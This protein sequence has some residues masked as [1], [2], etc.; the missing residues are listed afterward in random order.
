MIFA[1]AIILP[2]EKPALIR[3]HDLKDLPSWDEM[4]R[5][6]KAL[7]EGTFPFPMR[8]SLPSGTWQTLFSVSLTGNDTLSS[9]YTELIG[10]PNS[11]FSAITGTITQIRCNIYAGASNYTIDKIYIDNAAASGDVWDFDGSPV[12]L[13]VG[14]SNTFTVTAGTEQ[15]TDARAFTRVAGRGIAIRI[16]RN[17]SSHSFKFNASVTGANS[18]Y[19]G[20]GDFAASP[21]D[22]TATSTTRPGGVEAISKIEVFA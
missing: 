10:I 18:G 8:G 17:G 19:V 20:T 7:K 22:V 6:E 2:P 5:R 14:G 3:A 9:N 11:Q 4:Q 21:N 15:T 12:Q 16:Y 13:Q 1:P